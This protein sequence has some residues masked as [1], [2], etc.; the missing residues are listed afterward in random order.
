[1]TPQQLKHTNL[2]FLEHRKLST[3][4]DLLIKQVNSL[5]TINRNFAV[6]DSLRS[7]QLNR[8]ML[9]AE[10]NDQVINS[11]NMQLTKKEKKVKKLRGLTIGGFTVAA[12]LFAILFVK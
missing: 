6:V 11:L 10:V 2:I 5:E 8:C 3:E 4:V 9:Q 1:M 12:G 7:S